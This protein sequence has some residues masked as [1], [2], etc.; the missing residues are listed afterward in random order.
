MKTAYCKN[1]QY[2]RAHLFCEF[3]ELNKTAKL[4]GMNI[5]TIPTVTG[6]IHVLE[7]HR[8]SASSCLSVC[9]SFTSR[10]STKMAK[11]RIMQATTYDSQGTL[12]F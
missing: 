8:L 3:Q 2:S 4:K 5:N 9:L 10:C 1:H 12:V 6:I 7:L 11:P